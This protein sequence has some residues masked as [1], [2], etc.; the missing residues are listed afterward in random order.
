MSRDDQG[1]QYRAESYGSPSSVDDQGAARIHPSKRDWWIVLIIWGAVLG[2]VFGVTQIAQAGG[3]ATLKLA[4]LIG[5]LATALALLQ[6][7]YAT[8]YVV[9]R[10]HL[11]IH[12]GPFKR[13]VRLQDIES[14][15]P[16][17][18]PLSSPA[19]SLD[20]MHVSYRG[21]ALGVLI[22]PADQGAFL[23]DLVTHAPHLMLEADRAVRAASDPTQ[24][25]GDLK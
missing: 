15:V 4:F 12:C 21:S 25:Q 14:V 1:E 10:E 5:C 3:S 7:L 20:R 9:G 17:R 2:I 16:S 6:I 13:A 19:L 18:N 8:Y 24:K 23:A 22:S 11:R